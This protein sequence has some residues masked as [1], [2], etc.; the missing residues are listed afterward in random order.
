MNPMPPQTTKLGG[1]SAVKR[2]T[3]S[4]AAGGRAGGQ[5][6]AAVGLG[7]KAVGGGAGGLSA[8]GL[9]EFGKP[10]FDTTSVA[11]CDA[12]SGLPAAR[13]WWCADAWPRRSGGLQ[14]K[15]MRRQQAA[16][17]PPPSSTPLPPS[18]HTSRH[19]PLRPHPRRGRGAHPPPVRPGHRVRPLRLHLPPRA[20]GACR[21][22]RAEP[23]GRSPVAAG[24]A[25]RA[26]GGSMVQEAVRIE[27][28][29]LNVLA[30]GVM[31]AAGAGRGGENCE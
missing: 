26:A 28:L 23:A 18:V 17:G 16:S 30:V 12:L 19:R 13:M 5:P 22:F 2:Q 24:R 6:A 29:R 8:V 14:S 10:C 21:A 25:R 9:G 20:V 1:H 27:K 15:G 11:M 31:R 7:E 4:K 3:R